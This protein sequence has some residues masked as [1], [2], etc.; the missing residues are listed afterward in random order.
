MSYVYILTQTG[1]KHYEDYKKEENRHVDV[2]EV[3]TTAKAA[4]DAAKEWVEENF[5]KSN[6]EVEQDG[7]GCD[8]WTC[9]LERDNISHV[10]ISVVM[11]ALLGEPEDSEVYGEEIGEEEGEGSYDQ[12]A[13][14][15]SASEKAQEPP[16]KRARQT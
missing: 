10:L 12:D 11:K 9:K 1:Y 4:N 7:Q 15:P 8:T 6:N 3:Y 5:N 14:Q 16:T 13:G 2:L